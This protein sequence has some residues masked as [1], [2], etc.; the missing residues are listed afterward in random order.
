MG[1]RRQWVSAEELQRQIH[2]R[3]GGPA[4]LRLALDMSVAAR[5]MT[6]ARIRMQHPH[7]TEAQLMRALLREAFH[8]ADLPPPLR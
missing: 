7:F 1:A 4:R 3:L 5:A 8:P 2:R 6:L